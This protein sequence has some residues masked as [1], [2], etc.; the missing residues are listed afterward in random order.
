MD[1]EASSSTVI[2]VIDDEPQIRRLLRVTLETHGYRVFD[3][4][5]GQEGI[6][7]AALRRPDVI[8][9]DLG[10]P[11]IDGH[12]VL[13]RIREWSQVP[14][15]ILSVRDAESDKI[16]ALDQGADDYVTKPFSAGELLARLRAALRKAQPNADQTFHRVGPIEVDLAARTVR[17]EGQDVRLTPI[18]YALFRL[19]LL[20]SGRVL[21]HRYLLSQVWGPNAV[22]QTHY[23]RVHI[24]HLREKVEPDP[25]QPRLILTES[26]IGYRLVAP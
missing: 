11:D 19:L 25:Q 26:G 12:N 6:A 2:L 13:R 14:I 7:Q 10:L 1:P 4:D 22:Q 18:E 21:T 15:L 9:L 17:K 3:A 5:T 16:T 20:N 8:L 23:L 24:A